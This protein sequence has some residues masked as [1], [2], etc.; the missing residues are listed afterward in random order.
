[1]KIAVLGGSFNPIHNAHLALADEVCTTLGYDKVLFVPTMNPLHK[2]MA[3]PVSAQMRLEMVQKACMNDSRFEAEDCEI[4]RGGISYTIDTINYL[5]KKY[6][7]VLTD[8]IGLIIGDDLFAGFHL[9]NSAEELARKC[10]LILARRPTLHT[11]PK[12]ANVDK[13]LYADVSHGEVLFD[14]KSEPLF[15]DAVSLENVLLHISSTDIRTRCNQKRAFKYLVPP[16][17]F[18]YIIDGKLYE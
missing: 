13:G 11:D 15:A 14:I 7:H 12:Y 5:E 18:K 4:V 9:W 6:A 8:K 3:N 16:E 1:M 10:Q 2:V 17:V